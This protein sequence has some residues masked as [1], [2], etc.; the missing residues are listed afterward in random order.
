MSELKTD[1]T[2]KK[3]QLYQANE[4]ASGLRP[5]R[6]FLKLA[7]TN[8]VMGM[9]PEDPAFARPTGA[10]WVGSDM[11]TRQLRS[12]M[13]K[14]AALEQPMASTSYLQSIDRKRIQVRSLRRAGIVRLRTRGVVVVV[15]LLVLI[16]D[17][18]NHQKDAHPK[19]I[20]I[21]RFL[22]HVRVYKL[23]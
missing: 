19:G 23:I 6:W 13:K 9:G 18:L 14:I 8:A 1:Q 4:A 5:K 3:F 16:K 12:F 20:R 7:R 17:H 2:A 21:P 15:L 10:R 11:R 22:S